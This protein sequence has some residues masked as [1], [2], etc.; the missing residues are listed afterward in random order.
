LRV[1]HRP[2]VPIPCT[3]QVLLSSGARPELRTAAGEAVADLCLG[4]A[5]R[6][7]L[8]ASEERRRQREQA[9]RQQGQHAGERGSRAASA[10]GRGGGGG[11]LAVAA[12]GGVFKAPEMPRF[13]PKADTRCGTGGGGLA[14]P[15]ES[16]HAAARACGLPG[17]LC[18]RWSSVLP[19]CPWPSVRH[20]RPRPTRR[21]D[22]DGFPLAAADSLG[23]AGGASDSGDDDGPMLLVAAAEPLSPRPA[24]PPPLMAAEA[25][26]FG[27]SGG[28][29]RRE[30][31]ESDAQEGVEAAAQPWAGLAAGRGAPA[32][33]ERGVG[34]GGRGRPV[35]ANRKF[36]ERYS[37]GHTGLFAPLC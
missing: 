21:F 20:F 23:D 6:D 12:V 25:L 24:P 8:E 15:Q 37:L 22:S 18:S 10:S 33:A 29:A 7:V 34:V 3:S 16:C 28:A 27:A 32:L 35:S 9:R 17:P 4:E 26:G 30:L 11:G 31:Q 13:R 14:N 2:A 1:A 19:Q 36:L 5:A